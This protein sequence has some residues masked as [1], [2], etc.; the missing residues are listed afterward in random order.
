MLKKKPGQEGLSFSSRLVSII[1]LNSFEAK[2]RKLAELSYTS[3]VVEP[4][5]QGCAFAHPIFRPQ[6]K[7]NKVLWAKNLCLSLFIAHPISNGLRCHCTYSSCAKKYNWL[8][9]HDHQDSEKTMALKKD[10]F[11]K[12]CPVYVS[13]ISKDTKWS[14]L[15]FAVPSVLRL[16]KN[17]FWSTLKAKSKNKFW[18]P[19]VLLR[20][21]LICRINPA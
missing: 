18:I 20:A 21:K 4:N 5:A 7:K 1:K 9:I 14:L 3:G 2:L 19:T 8:S 13:S 10:S 17:M 16:E 12:K 15:N 6:V 11:E